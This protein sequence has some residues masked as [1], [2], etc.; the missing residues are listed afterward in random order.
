[1][2]FGNDE[3]KPIMV[4]IKKIA[5]ML[6]VSSRTVVRLQKDGKI[7]L[8]R[9]GGKLFAKYDELKEDINA[10]LEPLP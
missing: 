2:N 3:I 1:M 5:Q 9:M 7:R 10:V 6:D 4:S 8:Y